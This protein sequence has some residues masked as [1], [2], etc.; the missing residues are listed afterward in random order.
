MENQIQANEPKK[1]K[2][3]DFIVTFIGIAVFVLALV[4]LKYAMGAFHLI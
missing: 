3:N 2:I 1:K 4:F